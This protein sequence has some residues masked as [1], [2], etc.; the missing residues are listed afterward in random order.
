MPGRL[1]FSS[2]D[3]KNRFLYFCKQCWGINSR[4]VEHGEQFQ[5][6]KS[7]QRVSVTIFN[8]NVFQVQTSHNDTKNIITKE[9][10]AMAY[11]AT[12]PYG[13]EKSPLVCRAREFYDFARKLNLKEEISRCAAV[14]ICDTAIECLLKQR[15][16]LIARKLNISGLRGSDIKKTR[17][18][19][20]K[21]I[22]EKGFAQPFIRDIQKVREDIRNDIVHRGNVPPLESA[23]FC[24]ETLRK[25][26]ET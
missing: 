16:D 14:I 22:E 20:I 18:E 4:R 10:E 11:T 3:E 5:F 8:S 26:L 15:I 12:I 6:E 19:H 21:L 17:K 7:G 24:V 13:P 25:L 23:E 1:S 9:L 2:D